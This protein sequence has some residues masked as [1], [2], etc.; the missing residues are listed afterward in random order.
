MA[1]YLSR[2]HF[3]TVLFCDLFGGGVGSIEQ[4]YNNPTHISNL[5]V[6]NIKS[7]RRLREEVRLAIYLSSK[8]G[9]RDGFGRLGGW[10]RWSGVVLRSVA[11]EDGGARSMT[12]VAALRTRR[13]LFPK[14]CLEV[15]A[16][17]LYTRGKK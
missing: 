16:F 8:D 6:N 15:L 14:A 17:L 7:D 10:L 3:P 12:V 2:Q 5:K 9:S 4:V 13:L 11:V 1:D